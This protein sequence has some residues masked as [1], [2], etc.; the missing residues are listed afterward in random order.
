MEYLTWD[1][2][3]FFWDKMLILTPEGSLL[4]ARAVHV[5]TQESSDRTRSPGRFMQVP[6]PPAQM[7]PQL[8]MAG[9]FRCKCDAGH[10]MLISVAFLVGP[11]SRRALA[12][13][14]ILLHN[15]PCHG[16]APTALKK[17]K[18]KN[19]QRKKVLIAF[20]PPTEPI[21]YGLSRSLALFSKNQPHGTSKPSLRV[22]LKEIHNGQTKGVSFPGQIVFSPNLWTKILL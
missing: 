4:E 7:L 2:G 17:K 18:R 6:S 3:Y 15:M 12:R 14:P 5:L 8:C 16:S 21:S 10:W 19:K 11:L 1:R 22:L 9:T 20:P 13:T